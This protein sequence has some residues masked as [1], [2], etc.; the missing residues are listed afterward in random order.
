[1]YIYIQKHCAHP[2]NNSET[3]TAAFV[4]NMY[5]LKNIHMNQNTYDRLRLSVYTMAV[6]SVCT[7]LLTISLVIYIAVMG[8]RAS[9]VVKTYYGEVASDTTPGA[10][11]T[12]QRVNAAASDGVRKFEQ[13]KRK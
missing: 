1:M 3:H 5:E 13:C 12:P 9:T 4:A 8:G 10:Q 6:C 11:L 7:T 2:N